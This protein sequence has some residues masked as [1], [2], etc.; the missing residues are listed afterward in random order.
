MT[1]FFRVQYKK[2]DFQFVIRNLIVS[3]PFMIYFHIL[4]K[5][6]L[7]S[8]S[9][10]AEV[11]LVSFISP[12]R[13]L[14]SRKSNMSMMVSGISSWCIFAIEQTNLSTY[15]SLTC[16][17]PRRFIIGSVWPNPDLV[18]SART[19]FFWMISIFWIPVPC[20]HTCIPYSMWL[21]KSA[22]NRRTFNLV[23]N[24]FLILHREKKDFHS[25]P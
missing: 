25:L 10:R 2:L 12:V 21:L 16:R 6:Y 15:R 11:R 20:P 13:L 23:G 14:S 1:T 4:A 7:G 17:I 8:L 9:E 3:S 19:I 22:L 24:K 18:N 5:Q